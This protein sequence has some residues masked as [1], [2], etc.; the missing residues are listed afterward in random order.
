MGSNE[1]PLG[2]SPLAVNALH[3][4]LGGINRY[5]DPL[6]TELVNTIANVYSI[7]RKH[8]VCGHGTDS[9]LAYIIQAFTKE[10]DE[11]LTSEGT[12]MGWYVSVQKLGRILIKV[13]MKNYAYDLKKIVSRITSKTKLIYIANP[14]NPTGSLLSVSDIVMLMNSIPSSILVVLD[15][16]YTTY[17]ESQVDYP[18]G[19]CFDYPNMVVTRT[20]SKAYGLAGLRVG[21]AVGSEHVIET[22]YN[23]KLPFEPGFLPQKAAVAALKDVAFLKETVRV[24]AISLQILSKGLCEF[25]IKVLDTSA[26]F[27]TAIFDNGDQAIKFTKRCYDNGLVVRSLVAFGIP[28]GVRISSGTI[29]DSHCAVQIINKVIFDL[30]Q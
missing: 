27:I 8:I 17:V 18:N 25:K 10:K 9:L 23:I 16:A 29:K 20:L 4:D 7:K 2:P 12:F 24:N 3:Q 15:E 26:N 30:Q 1:N 28:E 14:N 21:F 22:L 6:A 19:L 5:S 13:P 11:V